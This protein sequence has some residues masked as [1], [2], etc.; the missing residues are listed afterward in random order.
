MS[1]REL[2]NYEFKV[3]K[4]IFLIGSNDIEYFVGRKI[5][6]IFIIIFLDIIVNGVLNN[7]Y[8]IFWLKNLEG[9]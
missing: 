4:L 2:Y 7:V 6:F 3:L 8:K 1:K 5:N 9:S